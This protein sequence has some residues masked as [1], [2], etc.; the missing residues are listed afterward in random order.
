MKYISQKSD[1]P[2]APHLGVLVFSTRYIEG[3]E[4]SR[5][6]PGHGYPAH[7]EHDVKYIAFDSDVD[8]MDW[9]E[10]HPHADYSV[11]HA[12]P[13]KIEVRLSVSLS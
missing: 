7:V 8:L 6:N 3:D 9:I 10:R 4:R 1:L 12:T 2:N 11:I 5:T 13:K